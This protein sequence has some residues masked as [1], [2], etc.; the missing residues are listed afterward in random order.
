MTKKH[1]R[2]WG[3]GPGGPWPPPLEKLVSL[4][5]QK[6]VLGRIKMGSWQDKSGF[7][8]GQKLEL[9]RTE[10]K[11]WQM[12]I[13]KTPHFANFSV[14]FVCCLPLLV[15]FCNIF[16]FFYHFCLF[17]DTFGWFL[18]YFHVFLSFLPVCQAFTCNICLLTEQF[19]RT[20]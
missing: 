7:L 13:Y 6:W 18:Q 5:G 11:A 9:G 16:M 20:A 17:S 2:S 4:A 10:L 12:I 8:A 1:R 19:G 3:G 15:S 14:I